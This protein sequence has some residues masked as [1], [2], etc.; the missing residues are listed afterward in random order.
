MINQSTPGQE[1]IILRSRL[2]CRL[3][4]TPTSMDSGEA[5]RHAALAPIAESSERIEL[6][7]EVKAPSILA[8]A[9][10][11]GAVQRLC[12]RKDRARLEGGLVGVGYQMILRTIRR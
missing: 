12:A 6:R 1:P 8:A 10:S 4:L 3:Q 2:Y 9:G 5:K 11:A 7:N